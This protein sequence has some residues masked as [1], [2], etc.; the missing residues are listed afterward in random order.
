MLSVAMTLESPTAWRTLSEPASF[1][2]RLF[3]GEGKASQK[4]REKNPSLLRVP[5]PLEF[6]PNTLS[7]PSLA[8]P[9]P[10]G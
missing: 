5:A 4:R 10:V 6:S 9:S 2:R 8:G 3:L 7:D 1:A